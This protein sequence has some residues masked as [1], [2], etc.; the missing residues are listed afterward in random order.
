L[1]WGK[2]ANATGYRIY[3]YDEDQEA[4]VKLTDVTSDVT[5]YKVSSLSGAQEYR[6]KVRAYKT[7]DGTKILGQQLCGIRRQYKAGNRKRR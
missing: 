7:V 5:S 6:F 2:V 1:K 3:Q 4:F